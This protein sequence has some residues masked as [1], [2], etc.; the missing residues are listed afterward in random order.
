MLCNECKKRNSCSM[1]CEDAQIYV[2]QD[3]PNYHRSGDHLHFSDREKRILRLL[4]QG[5]ARNEIAQAIGITRRQLKDSLIYLEK[6]GRMIV[7]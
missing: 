1:L 6:K 2:N 5:K 4:A 7:L 3:R